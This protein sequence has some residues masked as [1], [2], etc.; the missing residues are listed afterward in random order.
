MR[1][2]WIWLAAALA[3]LSAAASVVQAAPQPPAFRLGDTATPIE[4]AVTLAIDPREAKFSGEVRIAMRVNRAAPV[5]WLNA[6]NLTI[7][8][9]EFQQSRRK[10]PV[11]VV[12]GGEDF[13]G[14]EARGAE[15]TPGIALATIR[16]H[17]TLE[18]L[19]TRGLFRQQDRG[20][21]YV[22]SQFEA[23]NA[24]RAFPCFDEPGWKTP[25]RL[26]IDA[27][28]ADVVVSNT[29]ETK[30]G[31]APGRSGW[32][33]HEFAQTR[34]LPSYL[35]ALAIGPFEVVEGGT[36]GAKQTK[37]R[38]L[39]QKGRAE[40]ARYAKE[41]TPR[42]LGLL[43]E[44][45]GMPYPFEKLDAVSIPQTTNFGAMENV[46][47][48]TYA[49]S[50]LLATA[51]EETTPFKRRYAAIAAH[52]IAHMWFGNLVT[53]AWWNDTWLNEAF[54]SWMGQKTLLA[55]N[56]EWDAGWTAGR[57]R[58]YALD[59]DRLAS[60]RRVRNPVVEKGD[61][62]AAFDSITYNKGAAVLST[63]ETWY[64]PAKFRDGVRAFLKR[65]A[66]STASAEDFIRA[67]GEAAGRGPEALAVFRGFIEQPGVPLLD[68][69]LDCAKEPAVEV[70]QQRLRPVGSRAPELQWTTPACFRDGSRTQ[71]ADIG[72]SPQRVP[73]AGPACP[74]AL[75][76]NVAGRSYYVPRYAPPLAQQ[77][78]L[79]PAELTAD[80]MVATT[81]DAG[82][83]AGSALI[84][85]GEALAWAD[86]GL[87][88]PSPLARRFAVD[89]VHEQRD[90]WLSP[91]ETVV[92][93]TI[94]AQQLLPL[95][96]ELGWKEQAGDSDDVR[97]LRATLLPY[98]AEVGDAALQAQARELALAWIAK[99]DAVPATLTRAVLDTAGRFADAEIYGQLR[100]L[101]TSTLDLRERYYLLAALARAR[102]AALRQRTLAL[103]L[104]K[105]TNG[106]DAR[107]LLEDALE[108]EFNRRAAFDFL[109]ANYDALEAKLPEYTMTRLMQP[110]GALCTSEE[111][112]L[113][114]TFFK[115]RARTVL[116]GPRAYRQSLE[117]IDLCIAARNH[118]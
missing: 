96:R 20:E 90:A 105:E 100:G 41:V 22:V 49:S 3:V 26:T 35:V 25:W 79:R 81:V 101:A 5:L 4:Y 27:P 1:N 38:Y 19:S 9:A 65:H 57:A 78:R 42:L 116:G 12:D 111:R 93:S 37:L 102:D 94:L 61:I 7:D 56:P 14:F 70:R 68:V 83:L 60:A 24:R 107:D 84:S 47:M 46:G 8:A 13:V 80:E 73:L 71:C 97:D 99:R 6:T 103:T 75:V 64:T 113:F 30:A 63:F 45:F 17:G 110:L 32:T 92:K 15:F 115:E 76:A 66:Y 28:A 104:E 67:L 58:K 34:P 52:E 74:A 69:A 44:Y 62:W 39:T 59:V 106:R 98:A 55:L 88:H 29:P 54:A 18:P 21:W 11:N 86:A 72:A 109:R 16:Y 31:A 36:A 108:D 40:E 23:I 117:R 112:E 82:I 50:I 87:V 77:L 89:L 53:L 91:S 48:I 33:R 95:A 43:E 51:R 85:I 114:F 118:S 10:I 2:S